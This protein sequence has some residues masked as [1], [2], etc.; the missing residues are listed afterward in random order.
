MSQSLPVHILLSTFNGEAFLPEQL[1]SILAQ[2]FQDWSLTVRDDG[3]S[4]RTWEILERRASRDA[5]ISLM[6]ERQHLGSQGSFSRLLEN[7]APDCLY[8]LCDQD[9]VWPEERLETMLEAFTAAAEKLRPHAP[10]LLHTDLCAIDAVGR[11]LS[12]SIHRSSGTGHV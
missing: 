6:P 3:S 12:L 7:A 4:D 9:D 10:L 5:R 1:D 8:F 2:S 11:V